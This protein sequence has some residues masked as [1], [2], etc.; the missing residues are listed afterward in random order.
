[1]KKSVLRRL[2][3]G[4][5]VA[6]ALAWGVPSEAAIHV[7]PIPG[8]PATFMK[9]ADVSMT[10]E[11]EK[12]GAKFYD[13][14]GTQ[15]DEFDI[16]QKYGINWIRLRNR[17]NPDDGPG[18]GGATD[19]TRALAMT[20]RAH[21]HGMKVLIDFH[22]SD[23]WADPG[24][25][26]TPKAWQGHDKEQLKQDVY[27]YTKKV[28]ADFK[29]AGELPEMVQVGNEI[30]NGML[31][32]VGKFDAMGDGKTL[33]ELVQS[34]LAAVHDTDK[35]IKTMIHLDNGGNSWMYDNFFTKLIKDNGVNDFDII[36]L[37]YYPFWSGTM[38]EL[39]SNLDAISKKF[40][41]DVVV[42]ETS[43]GFTNQNFDD[44]KNPYGEK[45]ERVAGFRST[46]QGQATGLRTLMER[47]SKVPGGRGL[48]VFYWA[49][50]SY[51]VKGAGS[52]AG[53]GDEWDNLC[54]YGPDGKA[55]E[56]WK[57]WKDVSDQSIKTVT[58]TVK[59]IDKVLVE[60]GMGSPA[61]MPETVRVTYTDDHAVDYPVK[62][63]EAKPT[64]AKPGN[65]KVKGTLDIAGQKKAIEG[66]VHVT[67]KV[68]LLQNGDFEDLNLNGWTI[69]GDQCVDAIQKNGDAIGKAALH[70]WKDTAF[71]FTVSQKVKNLKPGK[72]TAAVSTQG[73]GGQTKYQLFIKTGG[74]TYTADIQDTKWNEWHTFTIPDVAI[75]GGEAEVG[76]IMEAAPGTWGT[77]DNFEFYRQE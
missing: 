10:P 30:T 3:L 73:G 56:S 52:F 44:M 58:P 21:A 36:G 9:G 24:K 26:T 53:M 50:D 2:V 33:A 41:K 7:N 42:V 47:V 1:M 12:C 46:V 25:Q 5:V 31:W 16:M 29:A 32:P 45:E 68:N 57:V 22:Y 15:M 14:D 17:N 37:S 62:W 69:T 65:Y 72:Y 64:F 35:G 54:M 66:S 61:R 67:K 51:A 28:L 34:G 63:T 27:D 49:P 70:Y 39:G 11:M 40:N 13:V 8:L 19:E 38:D 20:K 76:V 23:F 75:N 71:A 60:A 18:G 55:L 6:G 59:E 48:G 74:K 43:F 77:M 4:A